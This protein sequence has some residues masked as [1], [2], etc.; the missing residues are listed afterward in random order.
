MQLH[1][2]PLVY[3]Y[4]RFSTAEQASGDSLR[5]Q[6]E[7]A[8]KWA[9]ERGFEL[10]ETLSLSDEGVSAYRGTNANSDNAL[11]RFIYACSN[12]LIE[13]GSYLIVENLDRLSRMAPIYAQ[14]QFNQIILSGVTIVTLQDGQ[15]YSEAR[16]TAEPWA[17]M[18]ALMVAVR[19][20]E[21][22]KLKGR[23]VAAAWDEKRRKVRAGEA[24][25]LTRQAPA[26]LEWSPDG[27]TIH[28]AHGATVRRIFSMTLAGIGEHAI[29]AA[30]NREG[31]PVM[32]KGKRAG[33]MWHR[34]Y[35]S[36]TLR[37]PAVIGKLTPG[38]IEFTG[39]KR[40]RVTEEPIDGAF[41]PVISDEDWAA[42]R[43]LKDGRTAAVRG[44]NAGAPLTN[45]FAGLAHCPD[46]GAIMTRVWK[47]SASGSKA[48]LVCTSV[49][50]GKA[51]H[52]YVSVSLDDVT[53]AF[54]SNWQDLIA[55]IPAGDRGAD[56][57]VQHEE[58][59]GQIEVTEDHLEE[60]LRATEAQPSAALA[61]RVRELE[62]KIGTL[63]AVRDEV[64]ERRLMTDHGI[65]HTRMG[66]LADALGRDQED[67]QPLDI[68]RVNAA[69][70]VLFCEVTIDHHRGRLE[71]QWRQGG[72]TSIM[73]RWVDIE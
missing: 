38:R 2:M 50:A 23:R 28:E 59:T 46:C 36:K 62:L 73:Y 45:I 5:R 67:P 39:G 42:V 49:K 41:P 13:R 21:E 63:K 51:A 8:K 58:L 22:S 7:A 40:R 61:R 60:V 26:W 44:R 14:T 71:F 11:G 70:K 66:E 48:K 20:N 68:A 65:I 47:G 30:F 3:S 56:L 1:R 37:N 53:E 72:T 27:W 17:L 16:V 55:N 32:G 31:V 24:V 18:G 19:A 9:M 29:A 25:K 34:T 43:A 35:I 10:D 64:E 6:T 15:E 57:D 12:G 52:P 69:L 54:L 33:K 4:A